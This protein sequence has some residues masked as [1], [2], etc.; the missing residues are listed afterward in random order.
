M[1]MGNITGKKDT[2]QLLKQK[3]IL[4]EIPIHLDAWILKKSH[5]LTTIY[6]LITPDFVSS[7][8]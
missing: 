8:R 4:E 7:S 5:A 6:V 1:Q 2:V 3:S